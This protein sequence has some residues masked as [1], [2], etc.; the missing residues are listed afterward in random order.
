MNEVEGV[1]AGGVAVEA[2]VKDFFKS[3]S[4]RQPS[5]EERKFVN[6][7]FQVKETD[8]VHRLDV[9]AFADRVIDVYRQFYHDPDNKDNAGIKYI[10]PYFAFVQSSGMGKTK[11]LF[12]FKQEVKKNNVAFIEKY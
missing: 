10:G 3:T 8:M 9:T 1:V 4:Q 2:A 12:E 6:I 7:A 5:S 11:I